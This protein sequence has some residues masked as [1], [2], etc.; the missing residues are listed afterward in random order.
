MVVSTEKAYEFIKIAVVQQAMEDYKTAL[1]R[2]KQKKI[3]ELE[4]FFKSNYGASLTF[5]NGE[6][7][8]RMIKE[9]VEAEIEE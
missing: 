5:G 6:Y 7:I 2:G 1:K 9:E 4:D 3:A 8:I